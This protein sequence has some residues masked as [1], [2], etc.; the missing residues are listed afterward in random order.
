ML[1]A[2]CADA[3]MVRYEKYEKK[4]TV[5]ANG[6]LFVQAPVTAEMLL[7]QDRGKENRIL[8]L[9]SSL[10]TNSPENTGGRNARRSGPLL[11]RQQKAYS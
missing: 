3:G 10:S 4:Q 9:H 11:F 6:I 8:R 2:V 5:S 7:S 1:T